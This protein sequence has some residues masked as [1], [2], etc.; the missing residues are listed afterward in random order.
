MTQRPIFALEAAVR[1]KPSNYP[2]PFASMMVGRTKQPLGDV[3]GLK[4]FGV[5]LTT[6][7]PG[8]VTAL[9]HVHSA[10][11]EL[12]YVVSGQP[13]LI[14]DGEAISLEPG[15]VVGFPA[16]GPAHHIENRSDGICT[17]LEI[18]DR[19]KDDAVSYPSDDIQAMMGGDG[20]WQF[21]HKDGTPY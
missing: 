15:M 4:N 21:T 6:V 20:R 10:Q 16:S 2:E 8:A 7:L 9:Q 11:D 1:T 12:V 5:N 3:F 18:G 19:S 13:T 14:L 17:I